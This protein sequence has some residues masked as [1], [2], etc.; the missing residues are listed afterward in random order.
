MEQLQIGKRKSDQD[1]TQ[2]T[3]KRIKRTEV[4][5]RLEFAD[6]L[7][8]AETKITE[9]ER[10]FGFHFRK[11]KNPKEFGQSDWR[12]V[13][14]KKKIYWDAHRGP[15]IKAA[16]DV[17]VYECQHGPDHDV[18]RKDK[19]KKENLDRNRPTN[20]K[21]KKIG[22]PARIV[23]EE[24]VLFTQFL[25]EAKEANDDEEKMRSLRTKIRRIFTDECDTVNGVRSIQISFVGA[26]NHGGGDGEDVPAEA[27][28]E[29][30]DP[31]IVDKIHSLVWRGHVKLGDVRNRLVRWIWTDLSRDSYLMGRMMPT[32]KDILNHMGIAKS[33]IAHFLQEQDQVGKMVDGWRKEN[34]EDLI[35]F[36]G[37]SRPRP[38]P[39]VAEAFDA[40]PDDSWQR[41]KQ[42]ERD[43]AIFLMNKEN[44]VLAFGRKLFQDG[45]VNGD[46][47]QVE[48]TEVMCPNSRSPNGEVLRQGE[49]M[50]WPQNLVLDVV[51]ESLEPPDRENILVGTQDASDGNQDFLLVYQSK[52]QREAVVPRA[53]EI[54]YLDLICKACR[55]NISIFALQCKARSGLEPFAIVVVQDDYA[56]ELLRE[57]IKH[58]VEKTS[59]WG[60]KYC[61]T[62]HEPWIARAVEASVPGCKAVIGDVYRVQCWDEW[63]SRSVLDQG[64]KKLLRESLDR[65]AKSRSQSEHDERLSAVSDILSEVNSVSSSLYWTE[66]LDFT[67]RWVDF[68][69]PIKLLDTRDQLRSFDPVS[70]Q[71]QTT[72]SK[73]SRYT[74]RQVSL[75]N[76]VQLAVSENRTFEVDEDTSFVDDKNGGGVTRRVKS[77]IESLSQLSSVLSNDPVASAA[78]SD[79]LAESVAKFF[80]LIN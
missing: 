3:A 56:E 59:G 6:S 46:L 42:L 23:L 38:A 2:I 16:P 51:V 15:Y 80:P 78:M 55:S 19:R 77:A 40:Q 58:L 79:A 29:L 63:F 17:C 11:H 31:R 34:N 62:S 5:P 49:A 47:L 48:V 37:H 75:S 45:S 67:H 26:H 76:I 52:V 60:P 22:C 44:Q 32:Q 66:W 54:F 72:A 14:H 39:L 53:G 9:H 65:F 12:K 64:K 30:L 36:R 57:G 7:V 27:M 70:G 25:E 35:L 21:S 8:A 13:L 41:L 28:I 33:H 24:Q 50:N 74:R 20:S 61:L 1:T 43:G 4:K 10:E 18:G 69:C 73:A 68:L 71:F